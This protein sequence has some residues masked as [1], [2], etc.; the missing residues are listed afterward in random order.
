MDEPQ[1]LPENEA[2]GR[3]A[4]L[5]EHLYPFNSRFVEIE[6][7]RVHY[8]D[9]GS[10]PTL[11]FV[12]G[13]PD[14][15][16]LYRHQ[17]A[18]LRSKYRCVALD[19]PGFGLSTP[20]RDYAFTPTEQTN[21]IVKLIEHLDLRS[22]TLVVHD[23]GGPLGL[24]AAEQLA[25]RLS[26]LII[27]GTLAWP[28]Y[29]RHQS[30]PVRLMMS[31]LMSRL[32]RWLTLKNNFILEGPLRSE[33]NKGTDPPTD[34]VKAAYR[35]PF[36]TPKSRLPTWVLANHLWTDVGQDF[37]A[38]VEQNLNKLAHLPALFIFGEADR[39]TST[40]NELPRFERHFPE[41]E[42]VVIPGAGHFFPESAPGQMTT[43]MQEWLG[44]Q[45]EP[46]TPS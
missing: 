38:E 31:V 33:M 39:Y 42:T 6:N 45:F 23:W 24:R 11:L 46:A 14:Y 8:I 35:G 12:H 22:V 3:P 32:G 27:T 43:A 1:T 17:V 26:R 29:R 21:V 5:P 16:F 25:E 4:W 28:D 9:E 44:R 2:P 37:L 36:P 18:A 15:S 41:H 13:N 7:H 34:E 20:A 30:R 10:G 40:R 19:M